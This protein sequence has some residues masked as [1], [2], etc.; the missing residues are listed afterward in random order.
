MRF[1]PCL[2]W[3]ALGQA[4]GMFF[5]AY[6]GRLGNIGYKLWREGADA[7]PEQVAVWIAGLVASLGLTLAVG[8]IAM[9]LLR[10]TQER[11][12]GDEVLPTPGARE[13]LP[14]VAAAA[15]AAQ[16][17]EGE[18]ATAHYARVPVGGLEKGLR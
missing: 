14:A 3:I 5:Y 15:D 8:Q 6:L 17:A 11:A 12:Q 7:A 10:E 9:R 4:P 13:V 1:W 18:E 2:G 16:D